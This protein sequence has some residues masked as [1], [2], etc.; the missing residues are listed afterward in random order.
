MGTF[1][2]FNKLI[3]DNYKNNGQ[4]LDEIASGRSQEDEDMGIGSSY[5]KK[6][7]RK[8]SGGKLDIIKSD[9]KTKKRISI[10][11][12]QEEDYLL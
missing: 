3:N 5:K 4:I 12:D 1:S 9:I 10:L 2:S 7:N 11:E 8:E 6:L